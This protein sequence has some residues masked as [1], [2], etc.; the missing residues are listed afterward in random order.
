MSWRAA[1]DSKR[2][3]RKW[4]SFRKDELKE[5]TCTTERTLKETQGK[6]R[7]RKKARTVQPKRRR[8]KATEQQNL[9]ASSVDPSSWVGSFSLGHRTAVGLCTGKRS[10]RVRQSDKRPSHE[11]VGRPWSACQLS[12]RSFARPLRRQPFSSEQ[13]VTAEASAAPE[14]RKRWLLL[15]PPQSHNSHTRFDAALSHLGS[16]CFPYCA[17]SFTSASSQV[18]SSCPLLPFP[19]F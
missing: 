16:C 6:K 11:V 5:G 4:E 8:N 7:A 12:A 10:S 19:R 9:P 13:A 17:S 15:P 14:S 3:M 18:E 2:R 1:Q